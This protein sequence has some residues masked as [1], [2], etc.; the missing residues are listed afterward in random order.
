M[1]SNQRAQNVISKGPK[2]HFTENRFWAALGDP[3][4]PPGWIFESQESIVEP[5]GVDF[6]AAGVD[7]GASGVDFGASGP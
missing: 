2:R 7:F 1:E 5:S 3:P 6:G 4:G